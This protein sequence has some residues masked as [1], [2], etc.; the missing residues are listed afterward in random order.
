MPKALL[1]QPET[2]FPPGR[3][4]DAAPLTPYGEDGKLVG[5]TKRLNMSL[6]HMV[7]KKT[8]HKRS[9]VRNKVKSKLKSAVGLIV[10][11]GADVRVVD[12]KK[13]IVTTESDDGEKWVMQGEKLSILP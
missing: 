7:L 3:P 11:R 13:Q 2:P 10:T 1:G 9:V 12:G 6:M 4:F 5:G 8:V